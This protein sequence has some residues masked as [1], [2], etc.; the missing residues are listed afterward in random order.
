ML[1]QQ[2]EASGLP[3]RFYSDPAVL[4]REIEAHFVNGWVGVGVTQRIPNNGDVLPVS[5]AGRPL[6]MTRDREGKVHVFHNV[7]RHRGTQL[8]TEPCH[9]RN[10]LITCVYHAWSYGVD[11]RLVATP[12]CDVNR[13]TKAKLGLL[14][15][16]MAIWWDVVFVNLSGTAQPFEDF[17]RPLVE[18]LAE[19][20]FSPLRLVGVA[21]IP[22]Q[23]NWKVAAE[24]AVD[25]LHLPHV[26][27]Q[28]GPPGG[29][30][31]DHEIH[32]L[33]RDIV[34]YVSPNLIDESMR[35][36]LP[37]PLFPHGRA[38]Y[39]TAVDLHY[40]FPNT[41]LLVCPSFVQITIRE[42]ESL[43]VTKQKYHGYLLG[44]EAVTQ[45]RE[46]FM[47]GLREVA[48][49][50]LETMRRQQVGRTGNATDQGYMTSP[51]DKLAA[52]V[53]KRIAEA[54]DEKTGKP[55]TEKRLASV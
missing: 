44:E 36:Y 34:G 46:A 54:Y 43:T 1:D 32:I 6:L 17:I 35:E 11:G 4:N 18:H 13:E 7:C 22:A 41:S 47:N 39:Q 24:N 26:H 27:S 28:F 49:Q 21:D 3:A 8:I 12:N 2:I 30:R 40:I 38:G 14:P 48:T 9:P 25:I 45:H 20:D 42:P 16:R 5:V 52:H 50:D 23:A 19:F 10:G 15:V 37:G 55:V 29:S 53:F 51:F 31:Y 33:S